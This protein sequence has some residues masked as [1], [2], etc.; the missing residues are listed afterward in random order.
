MFLSVNFYSCHGLGYGA[1][2]VKDLEN[3]CRTL[4]QQIHDMEVSCSI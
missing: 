4:Q 2:N 3:K 1:E